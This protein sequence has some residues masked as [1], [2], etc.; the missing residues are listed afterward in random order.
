VSNVLNG[1]I[2][3]TEITLDDDGN[4]EGFR[5]NGRTFE[6][7][8]VGEGALGGYLSSFVGTAS[9]QMFQDLLPKVDLGDFGI[10]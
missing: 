7:M 9:T 3:G 4:F 8:T 5:F 2:Q 10:D 1:L 6:K